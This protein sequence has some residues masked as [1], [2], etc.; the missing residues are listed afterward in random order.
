MATIPDKRGY[1][2]ASDL[3]RMSY[4]AVLLRGGVAEKTFDH[5]H[6]H[7][8]IENERRIKMRVEQVYR[9]VSK[10]PTLSQIVGISLLLLARMECAA[11]SSYLTLQ[12]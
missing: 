9:Q 2:A 5:F 1:I 6:S 8:V 11:P 3:S 7:Q 12:S 10:W 4:K